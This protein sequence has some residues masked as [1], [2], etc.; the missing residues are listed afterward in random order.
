V[1]TVGVF[2][3]KTQFSALLERVSRGEEIVI[4]RHGR[5]VARLIPAA[6]ADRARVD[7]TIAR[8]KALRAGSQLGELSW[9]ELRDQGRR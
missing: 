4:T 9:N 1:T 6:L 3:A 8:L 5:P 2:E 7:Q